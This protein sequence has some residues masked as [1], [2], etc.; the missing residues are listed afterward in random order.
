M[1]N[2][3]ERWLLGKFMLCPERL[4]GTGVRSNDFVNK[5]HRMIFLAI[6]QCWSLGSVDPVCL[7]EE[8]DERGQLA[9][10]GGV[11]YLV[12]L[13]EAYRPEWLASLSPLMLPWKVFHTVRRLVWKYRW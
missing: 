9:E 5:S 10:V 4:N 13:M 8:L 3:Y 1:R 11:D 6:V 12:R 2:S 7:A